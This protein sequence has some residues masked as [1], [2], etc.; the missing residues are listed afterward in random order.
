MSQGSDGL[1]PWSWTVALNYLGDG[2][3]G[4]RIDADSERCASPAWW[5]EAGPIHFVLKYFVLARALWC[6]IDSPARNTPRSF[7]PER[8]R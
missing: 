6:G 1:V 2:G 5:P 3:E 8:C 7:T 4:K